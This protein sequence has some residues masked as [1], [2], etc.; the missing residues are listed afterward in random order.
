RDWFRQRMPV[1]CTT[2]GYCKP[3]PSGVLIPEIFELWNSAVMFSGRERQSALYR[4]DMVSQGKD[5]GQCTE[6]GLCVP[7][8]P[9]GIDIPARL[10]EAGAYLS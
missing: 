6:C 4:S 7:K 1:S 3:C 10:K 2:C 9:Q 8:C 5:T